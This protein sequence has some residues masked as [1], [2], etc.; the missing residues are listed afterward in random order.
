MR[1]TR[2]AGQF[3][4]ACLLGLGLGQ[5][6]SYTLRWEHGWLIFT[7]VASVSLLTL[8]RPNLH[9]LVRVTHERVI[10]LHEPKP[11]KLRGVSGLQPTPPLTGDLST[12]RNPEQPLNGHAAALDAERGYWASTG[13][14]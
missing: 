14:R 13:C 8:L 3:G 11:R 9:N 4:L 7:A 5:L 12:R 2:I 10:V 1:L 6:T